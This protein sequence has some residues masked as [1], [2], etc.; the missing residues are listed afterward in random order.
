MIRISNQMK[1]QDKKKKVIFI[2]GPTASGKTKL[3]LVLAKRIE[4]ELI[5]CDSMQVYKGLDIL[6]S[7]PSSLERKTIRHHLINII[8]P[9]QNFNV[10][11]F[12]KLSRKLIGQI[13]DRGKIPIFAG[14]TG[15]YMEC[16]LNGLFQGPGA[17]P[18]IRNEL[19]RKAKVYGGEYLYRRLKLFDPQIAE[20]IHPHDLRKIVRA[21]EVYKITKTPI[22]QLRN[23]RKGIL[24]DERF[25]ICIVG[26][27][28]PREK[29]YEAIDKR[30][31]TMFKKGAVKEAR[32]I[33]AK[34]CSRTFKQALGIKEID[35]Y[36]NGKI[37]LEESKKLLKQN[38]R[39]YAKRQMT[40][41]RKNPRIFWLKNDISDGA[42]KI[43]KEI[44]KVFV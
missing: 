27:S 39:R 26:L 14:G 42:E 4:G 11:E 20:K 22:S 5:S 3:A 24:S 38:T 36:L 44:T 16:L 32:R 34:R 13:H 37:S 28:V 40:W 31:D 41:F 17:N 23:K 9:S 21:L 8:R 43:V 2:V 18:K 15:F 29:L 12:I 33:L 1:S 25:K 6:S 19:Y 35:S 7:K 30:V 10:S